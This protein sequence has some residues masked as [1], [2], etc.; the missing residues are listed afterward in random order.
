[1]IHDIARWMGL[2]D[3]TGSWYLFWSGFA[4]NITDLT[5]LGGAYLFYVHRKCVSCYR[6][7]KHHVEGTAWTT[8]HRHLTLE[9]HDRLLS[10]YTSR[11]PAQASFLAGDRADSENL[12]QP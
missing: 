3:G 6:L 7:G 11:W 10:E 8:C 2:T 1:M 4:A 9:W 12:I 5:L